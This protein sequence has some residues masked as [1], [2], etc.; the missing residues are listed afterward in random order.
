MV[1]GGIFLFISE[2]GIFLFISESVCNLELHTYLGKKPR[3]M[4]HYEIKCGSVRK[5]CVLFSRHVD[6]YI[7]DLKDLEMDRKCHMMIRNFQASLI[8]T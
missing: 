1:M 5:S 4:K 8:H 2:G 3:K 7:D 6:L